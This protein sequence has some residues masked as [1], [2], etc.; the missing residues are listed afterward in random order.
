MATPPIVFVHGW[1]THPDTY[2]TALD[3]LRAATRVYAPT[4]PGHGRRGPIKTHGEGVLPW[5]ADDV[6]A[7]WPYSAPALLIGHS[8]GGGVAVQV[9][10]RYPELVSGLILV[11]PAG[12][13][14][15]LTPRGF[16]RLIRGS[17]RDVRRRV[18]DPAFGKIDAPGSRRGLV[19]HPLFHTRVGLA[20][21]RAHLATAVEIVAKR[22][23]PVTVLSLARDG[24]T[25]PFP[26]LNGV[27]HEMRNGWHTWPADDGDAFADWVLK[28]AAAGEK[29]E[30]P[31]G[32]QHHAIAQGLA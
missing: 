12:G 30:H 9:A 23:I 20:A 26:P 8:L 29:I 18:T 11:A 19:R 25:V 17:I 32:V 6:A 31:V 4:L 3:R 2:A 22:G 24:I 15:D 27:R 1:A 7:S 10:L 28:V 21:K 14:G 5:M 13:D 16:A